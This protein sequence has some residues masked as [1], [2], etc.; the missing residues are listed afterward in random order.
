MG[1]TEILAGAFASS[2]KGGRGV[3]FDEKIPVQ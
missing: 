2:A 3:A 1:I